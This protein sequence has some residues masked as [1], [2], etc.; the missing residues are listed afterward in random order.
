M[1]YFDNA[2]STKPCREAVEALTSALADNYSNPSSL[3]K[4]GIRAERTISV[5]EK[6]ILSRFPSC[7]NGGSLVFTSGGTESNNLALFG[8]RAPRGEKQRKIITTAIEHPSVAEPL[9]E[10]EKHGFT[11]LRLSPVA[12]Q[13]FEDRIISA[14]DQD[15]YLISVMAVNNETGFIIDTV[16]IYEAVKNRFPNCIV[17]TDAAQAFMKIPLDGDLISVSAHKIHGIKG[18]GGLFVRDTVRLNPQIRGGGQQDGLRS[19]TEP[20]GLIAS[21]GAAVENYTYNHAHFTELSEHL[22]KLLE[23]FDGVNYRLNS[24]GNLPHI[25]NFSV[26]GVKSEILL[27]FFAE[28]DIFISSGSACA[29]NKKS[30]SLL[31]FGVSDKDAD[32]ALRLSFSQANTTEEIDKFAGVL[33]AGIKRFKRYS[34]LT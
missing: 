34:P 15:V 29:R 10:I 32:S 24:R 6:T 21:F 9:K 17:H 11:V 33:E 25:I 12:G 28:N 26:N 1:I 23:G 18:I 7:G 22:T 5:A 14:V 27:H 2:A 13:S 4:G 30:R 19:G 16:R 20:T 3:H 31:D 8:S